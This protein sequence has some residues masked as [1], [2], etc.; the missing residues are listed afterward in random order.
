MGNKKASEIKSEQDT[1]IKRYKNRFKELVLILSV[2]SM[3][4]CVLSFKAPSSELRQFYW[5]N[6]TIGF[7]V[8]I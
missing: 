3:I 6:L 7:L 8:I 2:A 1:M 5:M 4:A